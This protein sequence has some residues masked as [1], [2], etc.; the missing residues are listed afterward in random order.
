VLQFLALQVLR[1]MFVNAE[2]GKVHV[3][4][5]N[6]FSSSKSIMS[7]MASE[8]QMVLMSLSV[9]IGGCAGY[10]RFFIPA[11]VL[12]KLQPHADAPA[13]A[14]RMQ[15]SLIRAK[16]RLVLPEMFLRA[17]IGHAEIP[18]AE[19]GELCPGAVVLLDKLS[20]RP[21]KREEG[22]AELRLGRGFSGHLGCRLGFDGRGYKAE[23]EE[24]V[25]G[26]LLENSSMG[27]EK[28]ESM[29]ANQISAAP[30]LSDVPLRLVVELARIPVTLEEVVEMRVGHVIDLGRLASDPLNLVVNGKTVGQG[31]LVEFDGQ[32]GIRL[33]AVEGT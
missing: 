13:R 25:L 12:A 19:F 11:T 26:A 20:L 32:L 5:D 22:R 27:G 33:I 4:L 2:V 1:A 29:E 24:I 8:T 21:D 18:V 28:G 7:L 6:I 31:E 30:L 16:S 9:N 10:F 23:V 3:R 17:E 14:Y 15:K